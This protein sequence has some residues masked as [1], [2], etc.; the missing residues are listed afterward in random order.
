MTK[1]RVSMCAGQRF[2]IRPIVRPYRKADQLRMRG[3]PVFDV[4]D[5]YV[6]EREC[7]GEG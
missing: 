4:Y 3:L 1:F 7:G 2:F 5:P 6:P